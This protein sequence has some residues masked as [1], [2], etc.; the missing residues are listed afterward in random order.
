LE[1]EAWAT[2]RRV[3]DLIETCEVEGDP[4]EIFAAI[5]EHLLAHFAEVDSK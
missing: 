1:P 2:L 5:E 4:Q 3:L